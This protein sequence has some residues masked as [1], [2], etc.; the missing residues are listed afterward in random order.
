MTTQISLKLSNK[1]LSTAKT[2]A[3]S[4]GYD[5]IQDFIRELLRERLFEQGSENTGGISTYLASQQSLSKNWLLKEEDIA[6]KHLEK[7]M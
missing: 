5:S 7:E 6:W 2:Y 1:M 4:K 3:D